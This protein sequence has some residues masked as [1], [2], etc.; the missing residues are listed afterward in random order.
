M[1][2]IAIRVTSQRVLFSP[3]TKQRAK[4]DLSL[5]I[6]LTVANGTEFSTRRRCAK[7]VETP[8]SIS[9]S[10]GNFLFCLSSHYTLRVIIGT[11]SLEGVGE[12]SSWISTR[13]VSNNFEGHVVLLLEPRE[14]EKVTHNSPSTSHKNCQPTVG[15][16][17]SRSK[18][19]AILISIRHHVGAIVTHNENCGAHMHFSTEAVGKKNGE[20][21]RWETRN[22]LTV[23]P[24]HF[25]TACLAVSNPISR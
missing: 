6:F 8:T 17:E 7:V 23:E 10:T 25:L 12:T 19:R 15:F 24:E 21:S 13:L 2:H 4:V 1:T 16:A 20:L 14:K 9:R 5:E 11:I 18:T 3:Q 22:K